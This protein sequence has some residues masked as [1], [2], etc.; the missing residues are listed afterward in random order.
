MLI[1]MHVA[2]VWSV[3]WGRIPSDEQGYINSS[4]KRKHVRPGLRVLHHRH[5]HVFIN[6]RAC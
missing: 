6:Y 4:G 3:L 1:D 2:H 5:I